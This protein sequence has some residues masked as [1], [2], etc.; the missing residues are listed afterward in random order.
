MARKEYNG[1][2]ADVWSLGVLL[3]ALVTSALPFDGSTVAKTVSKIITLQYSIPD[4]IS[5]GILYLESFISLL[6]TRDSLESKK[7]DCKDMIRSMLKLNP[8]E[9]ITLDKLMQMPWMKDVPIQ[10]YSPSEALDE[11]VLKVMNVEYKMS[12]R[13]VEEALAS[14][15]PGYVAATYR[16]LRSNGKRQ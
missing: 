9:R 2:Q 14:T 13:E 3:Y 11:D 16:I 8:S 7:T 1:K 4:R 5:Q 6:T 15:C 12:R 10:P